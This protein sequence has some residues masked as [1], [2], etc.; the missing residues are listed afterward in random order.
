MEGGLFVSLGYDA[1]KTAEEGFL[2][3]FTH[4]APRGCL[5]QIGS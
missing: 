5:V 1:L 4:A 2:A 3:L